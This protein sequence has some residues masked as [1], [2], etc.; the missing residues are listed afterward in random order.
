MENERFEYLKATM[1]K[2]FCIARMHRT[3]FERN[4]SSMGIHQ[5]QHHILMYLDKEGE[6]I[7]QKHI[8][9]K[10]GVSPAA[11]ARLLKGLE[12]EGYIERSSIENDSRFN[13]IIITEKG[14]DIVRKSRLM[15]QNTDEE[16]FA[17]FTDE[18]ISQ[19]NSM[20]DK[21]QK[22][23]NNQNEAKGCDRNEKK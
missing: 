20:L 7:S 10:F 4:I 2:M 3:L 5:S 18:E 19:F 1:R 21:I 11:I 17:D 13:K 23:L 12:A 15:F 9:E 14:K 16:I 22:R 8:A 6:I